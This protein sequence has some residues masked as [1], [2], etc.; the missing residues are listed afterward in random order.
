MSTTRIARRT[1]GVLALIVA[2]MGVWHFQMAA[3]VAPGAS[4]WSHVVLGVLY[5]AGAAGLL[6]R[7]RGF[8]LF[9][10]AL[11]LYAVLATVVNAWRASS[12]SAGVSIELALGFVVFPVALNL[13]LADTIHERS[14]EIAP[15]HGQPED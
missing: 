10:G 3:S 8:V 2:L 7:P 14:E 4:P 6:L 12:G 15:T 11:T 5:L 9:F 1:F 13:L